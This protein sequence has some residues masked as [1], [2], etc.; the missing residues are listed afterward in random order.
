[1]PAN[2]ARVLDFPGFYDSILSA[3]LDDAEEMQVYNLLEDHPELDETAV[4]EAFYTHSTYAKGFDAIARAN[5]DWL[6]L[7][8]DET[9]IVLTFESMQSPREYNFGTD[10]LFVTVN[11][12][13]LLA[14][15][16][17]PG[18]FEHVI[19]NYFTSRSGF[20]SFYSNDIE[21][22]R[23][24]PFAEWD[25]N[26]LGALLTAYLRQVAEDKGL[27]SDDMLEWIDFQQ[28][29]DEQTDWTALHASL[30]IER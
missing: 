17:N 12:I 27:D 10:V 14:S 20:I 28:A 22:W 19:Q 21:A 6:N 25:H 7:V 4:R 9:G 23:A 26:E 13:E 3:A 15:L 29:V 24:K 11:D 18:E 5:V 2:T 1:M 16:V 30:G 8:L